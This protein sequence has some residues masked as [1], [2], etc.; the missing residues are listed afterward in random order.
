MSA[1]EARARKSALSAQPEGS[2][3]LVAEGARIIVLGMEEVI[4][5]PGY[6][7]GTRDEKKN[8]PLDVDVGVEE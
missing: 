3:A 8:I 2:S 5:L 1:P 6:L 7:K 4:A